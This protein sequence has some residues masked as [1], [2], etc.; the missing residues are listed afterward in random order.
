M[1][2]WHYFN[3]IIF[4]LFREPTI[5]DA[6]DLFFANERVDYRCARCD[7]DKSEVSKRI[8]KLPR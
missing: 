5:Q 4:S 6:L 3:V 2:L 7:Y 8:N 1:W